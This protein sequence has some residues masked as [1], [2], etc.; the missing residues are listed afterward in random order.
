MHKIQGAGSA[1]PQ[2][3]HNAN[4]NVASSWP[5]AHP[6]RMWWKWNAS[7]CVW[8]CN[9]DAR[10]ASLRENRPQR[11]P[12]F[13][14]EGHPSSDDQSAGGAGSARPQRKASRRAQHYPHLA[15]GRASTHP[16][17]MQRLAICT[18]VR[19]GRGDRVPPRKPPLAR[20]GGPSAS[21]G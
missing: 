13:S 3:R 21:R 6:Q 2:G 5:L 7:A 17:G 12:G 14:P 8:P 1:R 20:F 19:C 10:S 16:S 18:A 11:Y 15:K 4:S 9:A